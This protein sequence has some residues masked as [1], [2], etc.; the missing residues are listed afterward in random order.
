MHGPYLIGS[1]KAR[2]PD[3]RVML[4]TVVTRRLALE[5]DGTEVTGRRIVDNEFLGAAWVVEDWWGLDCQ[6]TDAGATG[7]AQEFLAKMLSQEDSPRQTWIIIPHLVESL[8][9]AEFFHLINGGR[10]LYREPVENC[11]FQ[12]R[13]RLRRPFRGLMLL[14]DPPQ[15][16]VVKSSRTGRVLRLLDLRN[17]LRG[18]YSDLGLTPQTWQREFCWLGEANLYPATFAAFALRRLRNWWADTSRLLVTERLGGWQPTVAAQA[19]QSWRSSLTEPAIRI[20]PDPARTRREQQAVFGGYARVFRVGKIAGPCVQLDVNSYYPWLLTW[21]RLP[22]AVTGLAHETM[23]LPR[24]GYPD[25][26]DVLAEVTMSCSSGQAPHRRQGRVSW[27]AGTFRTV[28]CGAELQS[29]AEAGVVAKVHRA[30]RYERRRLLGAWAD[31]LLALRFQAKTAGSSPLEA[32]LKYLANALPGKFAQRY[33]RWI[34][35]EDDHPGPA[36]DWWLEYDS[37]T[38]EI[39]KRRRLAGQTQIDQEIEPPPWSFP[40]V[41]AFLCSAG[42]QYLKHLIQHCGPDKV[43]YCDTDSVIGHASIIDRLLAVNYSFGVAPGQFRVVAEADNCEIRGLKSY[44]I[45]DRV[46][47][48]GRPLGVGLAC[49]PLSELASDPPESYQL[50]SGNLFEPR[51]MRPQVSTRRQPGLVCDEDG[52]VLPEYLNEMEDTCTGK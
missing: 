31:K 39:T 34:D 2:Y 18:G 44:T 28:M 48:A 17:W 38:G 8:A 23:I 47:C 15:M 6:Q 19:W 25:A 50:L 52:W 10:L 5:L 12:T 49:H 21:V 41:T 43:Y 1:A 22:V 46:V 4:A 35:T 13:R 32:Y 20:D 11:L 40:A 33:R 30:Y 9:V 36:W 3:R 27:P 37:R 45:G 26:E 14:E 51:I 29:A 42:R 16:V 24:G 7:S